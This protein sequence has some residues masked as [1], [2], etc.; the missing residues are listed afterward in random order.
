MST[1]TDRS[2]N[3]TVGTEP[4]A[5]SVGEDVDP[6]GRPLA[7]VPAQVPWLEVAVFVVVAAVLAWVAC[8]PLW[9]SGEGLGNP[10]L[11]QVSGMAMMFTPLIAVIVA[12]II[13][14]RRTGEPRASIVRYLGIWPLRP[15]GRVL[16]MTAL[17][18]FGIFVLV[19]VAYLLGAAFGWMQVDLLG[20]SGF[21]AQ[22][23][24]LPGLDEIPLVVAVI[25]YLVIMALGSLLNVI[26][27]FG[28]EVGW[29]GWLL[30]SL[31]P[32]GTWPALLIVGV[33]WGLWH[34]PL[35][36]LGYN[37]AR[38]DITGLA[39]MVGGCVMVG[40]LFGWLRLRTGSGWP[41]VAA[42]AALNGSA[43]MLL[44]LFIDGSASTPDMALVSFLGVSGWIV[45]AIVIAV[46]F[47]TG[48]FR[49]QPELG[50]KQP[51][52]PVVPAAPVTP[53]DEAL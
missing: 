40:I 4:A 28:E 49:K 33:I 31:R 43:G 30:T 42:H 35:I 10:L 8:L 34:A 9:L 23:A 26:V 29:R 17:A 22:L 14:R 44:G 36:L 3:A 6:K 53:H 27:A 7:I 46:L 48:Q 37:F 2:D 13:Q 18:F 52:A 45:S 16:G 51:K 11:V 15:F 21:K 47:A 32:L 1:G 19:A 25:G 41:S 12:M 20:L 38:P 5:T 50:I 39:F 24:Q